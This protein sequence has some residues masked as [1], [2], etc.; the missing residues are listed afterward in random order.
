LH[1]DLGRNDAPSKRA[2][3]AVGH[4]KMKNKWYGGETTTNKKRKEGEQ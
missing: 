1:D 2:I 4:G 3:S